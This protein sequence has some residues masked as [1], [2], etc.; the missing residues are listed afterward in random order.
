VYLFTLILSLGIAGCSAFDSNLIDSDNDGIADSVEGSDDFDQDGVPNDKDEDSDGDGIL[1]SVETAEDNDGD[2]AA[3]FIDLDADGDTVSDSD[4]LTFDL[5]GDDI[6]NFLDLDSDGDG[7]PDA[8]DLTTYCSDK[9]INRGEVGVDCGGFCV[10]CPDGHACGVSKDC[11][12]RV[13][14]GQRCAVPTCIDKQH[15]GDELH[16][17]CGGTR[18]GP[19]IAELLPQPTGLVTADRFGLNVDLQGEQI[20]VSQAYDPSGGIVTSDPARGAYV[21]TKN[22]QSAVAKLV[23]GIMSSQS[24]YFG[25]SASIGPR[26]ALIGAPLLGVSPNITGFAGVFAPDQSGVYKYCHALQA[27]TP[28]PNEPSFF[29]RSLMVR[30]PYVAVSAYAQAAGS[31]PNVGA[32]Y[33]FSHDPSA[34]CNAGWSRSDPIFP[35]PS[36]TVSGLRFGRN[37]T[38][39]GSTMVVGTQSGQGVYLVQKQGQTWSVCR[40]I[41]P[42]PETVGPDPTQPTQR[43]GHAQS[44]DKGLLAISAVPLPISVSASPGIVYLYRVGDDCSAKNIGTIKATSLPQLGYAQGFGFSVSVSEPRIA[45]GAPADKNAGVVSG[46]VYVFEATSAQVRFRGSVR[47]SPYYDGQ[48]FGAAVALS[49][50][51]LAVTATGQNVTHG[52]HG[53]AF[54]LQYGD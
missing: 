6:A 43:F 27:P 16:N 54:L 22:A 20:I 3:N 44:I 12:S 19:C 2:G 13:C 1:D 32:V 39:D 18:C 29:G 37:M 49:S 47:A 5:D 41:P 24:T 48:Q 33:V 8:Q 21:V 15:N 31:T 10:G 36:D 45:I 50:D 7:D 30:E 51:R 42:P 40:R 25:F 28:V 17:D 26:F 34:A 9:R 23:T 53:A 11:A 14:S 52:A 35:P 46:A 4:E 38:F